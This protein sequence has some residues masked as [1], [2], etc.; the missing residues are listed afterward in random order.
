ML[1]EPRVTLPKEQHVNL[2]AVAEPALKA[3]PLDPSPFASLGAP[4]P[5]DRY[6]YVK[7]MCRGQRVLDLG[8]Y[9]E[10][11]YGRHDTGKYR[12]LHA[13]IADVAEEVLGVDA[14]EEVRRA[15]SIRTQ[16]GT[17][18]VYGLVEEL[19]EILAD[20]CPTVIVAG[21]L[22]EHTNDTL[23]WLS[24]IGEAMPG[25]RLVATTPNT[26]SII[27]IVLAFFGRELAHPDHIQ[28]YSFRT[29][30]TLA[31][32]VP[33]HDLKVTPYYYNRHLL[34]QRV[35][36]WMSPLVNILDNLFLRPVQHFFPLTST[37]LI[38]TGVFGE[39]ATSIGKD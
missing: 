9:D 35:P 10:T 23:G 31:N 24:R 21:E 14:S 7:A 28:V 22:I 25:V 12:W 39:S 11:E 16:Y 32:R 33:L 2:E 20:F 34:Y 29:L 37:G 1:R 18:I 13:E 17:Q 6:F 15:G 3:V 27:N 26:T 5:V 8:A 19:D 36:K 38:V 4:R 30:S